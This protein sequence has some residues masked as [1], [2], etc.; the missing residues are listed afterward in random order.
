MSADDCVTAKL[1]LAL[2][3]KV[4]LDS[5]SHGTHDHGGD[6][7]LSHVCFC[8]CVPFVL[9]A[10]SNHAMCR[11]EYPLCNIATMGCNCVLFHIVHCCTLSKRDSGVFPSR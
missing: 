3:S 10:P 4:I 1:L 8:L 6:R 9:S 5:E 11:V 7:P 2:A